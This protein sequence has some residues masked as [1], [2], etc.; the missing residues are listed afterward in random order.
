M[1]I[2]KGKKRRPQRRRNQGEPGPSY[3]APVTTPTTPSGRASPIR[4]PRF[5]APLWVNLLIGP[6]MIVAGIYFGLIQSKNH[7]GTS[8]LLLVA[9]IGI[10]VW[11]LYRASIQIRQRMQ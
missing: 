3:T 10:G 1:P 6:L 8:L 5:N 9:Y 2:Q 11:Y 7:S 4:G